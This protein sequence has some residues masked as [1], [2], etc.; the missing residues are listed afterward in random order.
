MN[1]RPHK[2]VRSFPRATSVRL[3]KSGHGYPGE[4][5][6]GSGAHGRLSC[7]IRLIRVRG[8]RSKH[9]RP[10]QSTASERQRSPS[11]GSPRRL[12]FARP[13]PREDVPV[14][15]DHRL[16]IPTD[17]CVGKSADRTLTTTRSQP[18]LPE[19]FLANWQHTGGL[20]DVRLLFNVGLAAAPVAAESFGAEGSPNSMVSRGEFLETMGVYLAVH[21]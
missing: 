10:L 2:G 21:A 3:R 19:C 9:H 6:R 1:G 7:T 14:T 15:P 4:R 11:L 18:R 13:C 17:I 16:W 20:P 5:R 12:P 8:H